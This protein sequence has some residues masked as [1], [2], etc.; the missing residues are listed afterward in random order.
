MLW[1]LTWGRLSLAQ[2]LTALVLVFVLLVW[3]LT[4][5][6]GWVVTR[7]ELNELLD[8]HLAQTAALLATGEVRDPDGDEV[9]QAPT[10]MH[11]YQARVAFQVWEGDRLRARSADAPA[12]PLAA[13]GARGLS[14]Q[15][16][17]GRR[18]RVFSAVQEE[19]GRVKAVIH[20]G[21]HVSARRDVL[22]AALRGTLVPLL[23]TL[24]LLVAGV[25]WAVG[26]AVR[27]LRRLG[28]SVAARRPQALDALPEDGVPPEVQPLVRA[29]NGLFERVAEQLAS[30]RRFTAD[31]AH[32]LRTPIAAIRMHA[33]VAQGAQGDGERATA[34]AATVAGCDRATHLV[35]Q[36]LQ[37]ARLEADAA[38]GAAPND[39]AHGAASE[40][41]AAAAEC[42]Q[43]LWTQAEA[44]GQQ[45]TLARPPAPVPVAMA[46]TLLA[47]LLRNLLDNALRYSPDG[48]AVALTVGTQGDA[49]AGAALL[50]VEDSGPG[51]PGDAL[52]RLGER[53]FRQLGTG[54]S[55]SGLGW[56][57][58][59]RLAR[60]HG[61]S[62]QADRSPTLGGL[63]VRVV[64]PG[65]GAP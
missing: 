8:A 2:R 23:L 55:G 12:T 1:P 30:E 13:A 36:L 64:W 39:S 47:V 59:R 7:H 32:E 9:L 6:V 54:Q 62:V 5:A 24:P 25:W 26:R 15:R 57:I 51:L 40:L 48:A 14:E 27:P 28:A 35:E 10:L 17:D 65:E 21:E 3:A 20:V 34:L 58:V 56:S 52:A 16:I 42:V 18:W 31:A 60:L 41:G 37:L 19:G 53:F 61:L 50:V 33:Q 22:L 29:L 11:K 44:R 46:P 45:V 49:A 63:R 38:P 4:A 43:L